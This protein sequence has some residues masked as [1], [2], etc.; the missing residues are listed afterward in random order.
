MK[1]YPAGVRSNPH[2]SLL[3]KIAEDPCNNLQWFEVDW[4][5]LYNEFGTTCQHNI[6]QK[7][8]N[9]ISYNILQK[10]FELK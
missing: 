6:E 4:Y 10:P 2:Q 9:L 7:V 1:A 3:I 8:S 5:K